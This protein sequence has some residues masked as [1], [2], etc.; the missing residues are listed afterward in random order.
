MIVRWQDTE[1][2]MF[3]RNT[4]GAE[5]C[6]SFNHQIF[7]VFGFPKSANEKA[8]NKLQEENEKYQDMIIPCKYKKGEIMF[9]M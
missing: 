8:L 4:V 9:K 3:V 2:R 6:P 1:S 5:N 7:F